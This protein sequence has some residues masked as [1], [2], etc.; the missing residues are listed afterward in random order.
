MAL[1]ELFANSPTPGSTEALTTLSAAVTSTT[2]TTITV[3][4]SAPSGLQ[5]SG[6]FRISLDSELLLVT[7]GASTTT[8]TVTRGVEGSTAATHSSGADV[9]NIL[10]AGALGN[11]SDAVA[12]TPSLRTLGTGAQQA[13]A[14]NDGRITGAAPLASPV[15]TGTPKAPTP[16]NGDNSTNLATTAFV[17]A[18]GGTLTLAQLAAAQPFIVETPEGHGAAHNGSTDDTVAIQAAINAAITRGQ[19]DGSNYAEVWFVSS[20]QPYV[21]NGA[22]TGI[23]TPNFAFS[24]LVLPY[25]LPGVPCF[26]LVLKGTSTY[27][28]R[29]YYQQTV[30]QSGGAVL[31]SNLD[32]AWNGT[33]GHASVIG[34]PTAEQI[35]GGGNNYSNILVV[36]EGLD[37]VPPFNTNGAGLNFERI[38]QVHI[39]SAT[40]NASQTAQGDVGVLTGDSYGVMMP[41]SGNENNCKIDTLTIAGFK[42]GLVPGEHTHA[43]RVFIFNCTS[44][45]WGNQ[46]IDSAYF[47]YL[48]IESCVKYI[49]AS[50]AGAGESQFNLNVAVLD[51]EDDVPSGLAHINDPF[52]SLCGE[53]HYSRF[54]TSQ[55]GVGALQ[56]AVVVDGGFGSQLRLYNLR[57]A[58]GHV[59]SPSVPAT[60]VALINPF[61]RDAWVNVHGGTVT[62][63]AVGGTTVSGLTAGAVRVPSRQ[64]ITITYSAA[65]SWDWWLD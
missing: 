32:T 33:D 56:T 64:T 19:A 63:I 61:D 34:G 23:G 11:Q 28:A 18:N 20:G 5:A 48:S 7:G 16:T 39:K 52:D 24:Q 26:T 57:R 40:V 51:M 43:S 53:I 59:T 6:Q 45:I 27:S 41:G 54:N 21:V 12:G 42:H 46:Y 49:D 58:P 4:A 36:V 15:F 30:P 50:P 22:P 60:T 13:A 14:G 9:W 38:G 1:P 37:V 2:A 44:G 62:V 25:L 29:P 35:P 8:W 31:S 65:P 47:E 17:R 3:A 55:S 10:T